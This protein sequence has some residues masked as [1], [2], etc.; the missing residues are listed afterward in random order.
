MRTSMYCLNG[1]FSI[2]TI[3]VVKKIVEWTYRVDKR[4]VHSILILYMTNVLVICDFFITHITDPSM[5]FIMTCAFLISV[6]FITDPSVANGQKS[7][8]INTLVLFSREAIWIMCFFPLAFHV[9]QA[10]SSRKS[11]HRK[12]FKIFL[13]D[14]LK[15]SY[16]SVIIPCFIYLLFIFTFDLLGMIFL[17]VFLLQGY[18]TGRSVSYLLTWFLLAL[19]VPFVFLLLGARKW[20]GREENMPLALWMTLFGVQRLLAPGPF[21]PTYWFPMVFSVIILSWFPIKENIFKQSPTRVMI[22]IVCVNIGIYISLFLF[23]DLIF[24]NLLG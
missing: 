10:I 6:Q 18:T 15:I 9:L 2:G 5:I 11:A 20:I 3:L 7:M 16:F 8:I 21:Y 4:D 22:L 13:K 1:A 23:R 24:T 17:R 12:S 14:F 19:N